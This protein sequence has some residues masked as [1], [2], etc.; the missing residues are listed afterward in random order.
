MFRTS[1]DLLDRLR[2]LRYLPLR[3][4][5]EAVPDAL[6][7]STLLLDMSIL[8]LATSSTTSSRSA[9]DM[10]MRST[11]HGRLKV[12]SKISICSEPLLGPKCGN[13]A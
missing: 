1:V 8:S 6:F 7:E 9:S 3:L 13:V 2:C 10:L 5:A 11:A 12:A 4:A